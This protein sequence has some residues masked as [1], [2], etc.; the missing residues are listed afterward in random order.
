MTPDS[1]L[2]QPTC[3]CQCGCLSVHFSH[4]CARCIFYSKNAAS[5]RLFP[6]TDCCS[7]CPT[8]SHLRR[9]ETNL[10]D[11]AHVI[12]SVLLHTLSPGSSPAHSLIQPDGT[13]HHFRLCMCIP[14]ASRNRGE[15][16][17]QL[18]AVPSLT[19]WKKGILV[20]KQS[21]THITTIPKF[22][23]YQYKGH[24][25]EKNKWKKY[26]FTVDLSQLQIRLTPTPNKTVLMK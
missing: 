22:W 19:D 15:N 16:I 7:I 1:W 23:L 18:T 26:L 13:S 9:E 10:S 3:I 14:L 25:T 20:E 21:T 5:E 17:S 6:D 8:L 11:V 24:A 2:H 4:I 12:H